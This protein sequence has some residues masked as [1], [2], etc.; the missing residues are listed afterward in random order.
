VWPTPEIKDEPAIER[1]HLGGPDKTFD[2]GLPQPQ[3][4]IDAAS[5]SSLT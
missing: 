2:T 1:P 4:S 3:G 5:N